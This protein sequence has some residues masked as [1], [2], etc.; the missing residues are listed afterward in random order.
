[1]RSGKFILDGSEVFIMPKSILIPDKQVEVYHKVKDSK[2]YG[3]IK[4]LDNRNDVEQ[5]I[6]DI[7]EKYSDATHNVS[8]YKLKTNDNAITYSDDDGEPAGSSG[9]PV[10]Q[11][12]EGKQLTNTVI[13]ITRY[14]GGTKLGIGGLIRAYGNTARLAIKKA[15]IKKLNLIYKI[16][17]EGNYNLIG[18]IMGQIKSFSGKILDTDYNNTGGKITFLLKPKY[19]KKLKETLVEITSD[20]IEIDKINQLYVE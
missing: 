13:V 2:F 3:N 19:Y 10:L 11:A 1:M 17:A 18:S 14:F 7:K 16:K 12:I 6:T 4:A 15:G 8:A 5:F 9:S 20:N